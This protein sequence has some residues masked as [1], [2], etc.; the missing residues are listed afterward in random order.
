MTVELITQAD[1]EEFWIRLSKS[2]V[3]IIPKGDKSPERMAPK[4]VP[5]LWHFNNF[6]SSLHHLSR[7]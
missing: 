4:E 3:A 6:P 7:T 1:F 5:D 2:T